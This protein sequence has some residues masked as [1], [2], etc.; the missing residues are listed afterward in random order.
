MPI[1]DPEVTVSVGET[2]ADS[3]MVSLIGGSVPLVRPCGD[4][5]GA[6]DGYCW[7]VSRLGLGVDM[8]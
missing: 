6:E 7:K 3:S 5:P 4:A 1:D 8:S 2:G